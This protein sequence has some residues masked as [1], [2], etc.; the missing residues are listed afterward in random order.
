MI[1][2]SITTHQEFWIIFK[3]ETGNLFSTYGK[4]LENILIF[5]K[6]IFLEKSLSSFVSLDGLLPSLW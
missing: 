2:I 6:N 1:I 4:L 5:D 3:G